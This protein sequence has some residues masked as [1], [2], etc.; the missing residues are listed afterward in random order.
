MLVDLMISIRSRRDFNLT[1]CERSA[2]QVPYDILTAYTSDCNLLNHYNICNTIW[3][4][5][6][7]VAYSME[8]N[9]L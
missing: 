2:R 4:V 6:I 9:C 1:A 5:F 3:L 8:K 7:E